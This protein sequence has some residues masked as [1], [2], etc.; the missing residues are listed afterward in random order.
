MNVY[1]NVAFALRVTNV[2]GREIRNRVPYILGLVGL[3]GQA[4]CLPGRFLY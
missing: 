3:S 2:S 1:D 4:K